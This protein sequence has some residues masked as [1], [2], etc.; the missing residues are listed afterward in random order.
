MFKKYRNE[1]ENHKRQ[2]PINE[3]RNAANPCCRN[4]RY[5]SIGK[6]A[7]FYYHCQDS[8]LPEVKVSRSGLCRNYR[9]SEY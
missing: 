7:C 3:A 2:A 8:D 9:P 6:D 1:Y 5:F 4:C